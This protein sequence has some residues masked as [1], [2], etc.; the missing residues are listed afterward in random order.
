M[1]NIDVRRPTLLNS[2]KITRLLGMLN[3]DVRRQEV[4]QGHP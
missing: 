1:L 2:N 3:I 4:A